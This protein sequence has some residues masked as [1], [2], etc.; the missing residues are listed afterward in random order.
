MNATVKL[1]ATGLTALAVGV[2]IGAAS[3]NS[4]APAATKAPTACTQ[5]L[6]SADTVM[7]LSAQA[8]YAMSEGVDAGSR[9][10]AAGI[11]AT[12]EKLKVLTPKISDAR[13]VYNSTAG[14]CRA[15]S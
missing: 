7:A 10:D 14:Q 2:G 12:T 3:S 8:L 15:A 6:D 9:F 1:I 11:Q 13:Q 4:E 5:A